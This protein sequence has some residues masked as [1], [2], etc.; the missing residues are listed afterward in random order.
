MAR[1]KEIAAS[2]ARY[3]REVARAEAASFRARSAAVREA[4]RAQRAYERASVADDKERKRLY[5]EARSAAVDSDNAA[6]D[7]IVTSLEGLLEQTLLHDDRLDFA[8]L[9]V[10]PDIV[11]LEPGALA[12]AEAPPSKEKFALKPLSMVQALVPGAKRK[13]AESIAQLELQMEREIAAHVDR[14]RVRVSRLATYQ[15][16]IEDTNAESVAAAQRRNDEIRQFQAEFEQGDAD[17][18]LSYFDLVLSR[19]SYPD[20]FPTHHRIAYLPESKQL[21]VEREFPAIA[22]VPTVKSFRFVKTKDEITPTARATAQVR[23]LYAGVIAQMSLRTLHEIFE[24][25]TKLFVETIVFNGFVDAIDPRTGKP[26]RPTLVTLRT[27]RAV[28]EE[29]DLSKIDTTA[30]LQHLGASV[31]KSPSELTPVRPVLEFDMVDKRFIE[32]TDILAA[33]D[34]RPNLME[35]TPTEFETLVS[36]LFKAM[37]LETRQT[38]ASRD[39]GVDAVAFDLRPVLGGKVVIQAKRYKGTV[40]VGAVRDLYGTL[41]N[42]GASKGILVTTS[43]YGAASYEFANGK[44]LELIDGAGLLHLLAEHAGI[45]AKIVP[46]E[47]WVDPELPS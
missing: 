14:E 40:G 5:L 2:V 39:G 7:Q 23:S 38:R 12:I 18:V 19:S 3:Q 27:T 20:D 33:L 13:H 36:N 43:G 44:P 10:H 17:A 15:R 22:V 31:S 28:F 6:L 24:A 9:L 45:E 35:L 47:E 25:D 32:E 30:C 4:E 1:R 11:S 42:E 34:Q 41:L 46:P 37:G 21:V 16:G 26:T 29:I 8:T